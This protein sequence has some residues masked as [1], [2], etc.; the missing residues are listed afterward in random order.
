MDWKIIGNIVSVEIIKKLF[1]SA[2]D[3]IWQQKY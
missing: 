1:L 3:G 2:V